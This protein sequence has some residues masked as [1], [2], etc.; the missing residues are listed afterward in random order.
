MTRKAFVAALL[1]HL[2]RKPVPI[3][4]TIDGREVARILRRPDDEGAK[5]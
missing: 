5:R 1:R 3:V 2:G 4:L